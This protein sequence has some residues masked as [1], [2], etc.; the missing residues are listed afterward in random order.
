M[1]QNPDALMLFAAGF[2]TRMGSLTASRP[3]PLVEVG[4]M[5][6]IDHALA[7][8]DGADVGQIVV[9]LHYLGPMIREHLAGRADIAFSEE[10]PALLDTGGGLRQAIPMLGQG[11]V[12]TL[13]TDAVWTGRN[14]LHQ[15]ASVWDPARM[16]GLVLLVPKDQ[17]TG[18]SGK[19]DFSMDADGRLTRGVEFIYTGAQIVRTDLLA[20]VAEPAFSL[21]RI[22]DLMI[23]EGRLFGLIHEGGWCDV[24][25]PD[26]IPLAEALLKA[27]TDV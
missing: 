20:T 3:K 5:A 7:Q 1:R 19:G 14:I 4:G 11:P 10:T 18:H 17:A 9:N 13:N 27:T 15:L 21:N 8:A 12:F 26:S 6:L 23:G 25:R 24:G 16:D 2:G 22:W